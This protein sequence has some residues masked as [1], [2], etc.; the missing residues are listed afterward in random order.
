MFEHNSFKRL[1]L[2]KLE[3]LVRRVKLLVQLFIFFAFPKLVSFGLNQL[4]IQLLLLFPQHG[5]V[6]VVKYGVAHPQSRLARRVLLGVLQSFQLLLYAVLLCNL[7]LYLL[8]HL[9]LN[10]LYSSRERLYRIILFSQLLLQLF[11]H[12]SALVLRLPVF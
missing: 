5:L 6:D 2:Q 7:V 3:G 12:L 11:N 1:M 10:K 4:V 8:L 9:I